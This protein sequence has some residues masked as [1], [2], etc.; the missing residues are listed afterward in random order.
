MTKLKKKP[1]RKVARAIAY[2]SPVTSFVAFTKRLV[3]PGFDGMPL[4]DVADFFFTGIHKGSIKTRASSLAFSFFLALF[5]AIIFLFTLI[6]YIPLP[7]FQG[8]LLSLIK[9]VLP[10]AA[11]ETTRETIEDIVKHQRSGLL[12]LGFVLA[13]YFTSNGFMAMMKG[14]NT[15]YHVPERRSP[16]KQ[17]WVAV[18]LTF[19]ISLLVLIATILIVFGQ[20]AFKGLV[21]KHI[22]KNATQL[23]IVSSI[24]WIVVLALIFFAT[25]FLYYYAPSLRKRWRFYSAGSI[26]ATFLCV[27]TSIGFAYYVNN[28][29]NYN[30][31]YGSI[32]TLIVIML[33]IYFNSLILILGFEL[34]ASI[35][36]AKHKKFA[37]KE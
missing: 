22:I 3:L 34:N 31:L 28:F 23:T 30:K 4:Y 24:Q 11:Y 5:P 14:F 21:K 35:D 12:S 7:N 13:L 37:A 1:V 8:Q 26:L 36:N 19:I 17:R 9:N 2:S 10:S 20:M 32:G 27:C 16:W 33:W 6:P 15:S 29:A 18:V 25:S